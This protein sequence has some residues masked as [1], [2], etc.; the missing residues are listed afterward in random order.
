MRNLNIMTFT[1]A[2]L[3]LASLASGAENRVGP[4]LKRHTG[5]DP[6]A[7]QAAVAIL[8]KAWS[9]VNAEYP[10]FGIRDELDWDA[11]RRTYRAEAERARSCQEVATIV[12][13]MLRHLRDGHVWVKLNGKHL[14]VFKVPHKLNVNRNTRIYERFLGRVQPVGRRLMWAKTKDN[15]GWLM[16]PGWKGADLP[17]RFDD[18]ME[19]MRD[20][21]GLILDVRWNSGGDAELSKYIAARFVDTTR[22]FGY[23]R[24]RNG[25]KRTDLT[26]KIEREISPRGPWRYDR[27]V[28][29]L[30][31]QGCFSAC[32]SFCAMMAACP[33]ATTMGDHTRGSTGFP[34]PFKLDGGIEI[35]VPQWIAYLPDGQMMDGQGV[36]PEVPFAPKPNSFTG[37][38]DELLSMALERLRKQPLPAKPIVGPTIQAVRERQEAERN[39]KPKVVSLRP[40][41]GAINVASDTELR[42]GFDRPMHPSTLQLEWQA[43]GFHECGQIRYD[44]S[45]HEFVI[46]VRLQAAC[47]H[48]VIINPAGEQAAQKGF[49]S[50]CRTEAESLKWT[51][52]TQSQSPKNESSQHSVVSGDGAESNK[53]GPAIERFNEIRRG[54]WAFVETIQAQ[55]YS[56]PGPRGYQ[57]MRAY[58]TRFAISGEREICADIGEMRG[59]PL[60]VFG[61]GRMNHIGGYYQ[62]TADVEEIVFCRFEEMNE[63]K[64][65]VADPFDAQN[66]DIESTIRQ[67]GLQ[68]GG[69]EIIDGNPCDI[70]CSRR[71]GPA[72]TKSALPVKA[73]WIDQRSSLLAKMI[74]NQSDGSKTVH[75][76]SYAHVN[77][78][79]NFLSYTPDVSYQWVCANKKMAEPLEDGCSGRFIEIRDGTRGS[80]CAAWGRHGEK[81]KKG[82]AVAHH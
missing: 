82:I 63:R 11:L 12:A 50:T 4:T 46:P 9:I 23:Y 36:I 31:G 53:V 20:T 48:R 29:L 64:V 24:Y 55:E 41:E 77:E 47:Q 75:R 52:S 7:S 44:E 76:F 71:N 60:S 34:V 25:P 1:L 26:E 42:I 15:I 28:I 17:D 57:A 73:W 32:E 19:Q 49:Q 61:E 14:P 58:A 65:I 54:M 16:I 21:R 62:K 66:T 81:G 43:G 3:I 78:V 69:R 33:N 18:V 35:H 2:T 56:R 22:I 72:V 6:I 38:R 39:Y 67:L 13:R 30:M 59:M 40:S 37:N 10:M 80:V 51:F 27:P 8:E 68:Y 45:K 74:D 5:C 79:L 70:V